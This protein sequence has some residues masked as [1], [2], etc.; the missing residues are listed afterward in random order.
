MWSIPLV[1]SRDPSVYNN[2]LLA[3]PA[4][5]FFLAIEEDVR[6]EVSEVM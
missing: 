3:L 6:I 1:C 4:L 2:F 5:G